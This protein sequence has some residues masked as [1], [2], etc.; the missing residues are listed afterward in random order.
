MIC[1]NCKEEFEKNS[2]SVEEYSGGA[3]CGAIVIN[4][5][6]YFLDD[7][8]YC[9]ALCFIKEISERIEQK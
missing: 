4:G 8:Y 6:S 3:D 2:S 7:N 9:S 5:K 1:Y